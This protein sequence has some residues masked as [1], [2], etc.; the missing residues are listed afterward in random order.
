VARKGTIS[1]MSGRPHRSNCWWLESSPAKLTDGGSHDTALN[2]LIERLRDSAERFERLREETKPASVTI[3]GGLYSTLNEQCGVW[4]D[5]EQMR[6]LS[7][8]GIGWGLDIFVN[9]ETPEAVQK[10]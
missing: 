9:D 2:L 4:L 7:A 10:P 3:Y 8:C 5:P 6:V 1:L